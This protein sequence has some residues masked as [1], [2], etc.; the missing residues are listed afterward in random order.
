MVTGGSSDIVSKRQ[1]DALVST[2][3]SLSYLSRISLSMKKKSLS[4]DKKT[5]PR[6]QRWRRIM[7][8]MDGCDDVAVEGKGM[9]KREGV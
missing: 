8:M 6:S 9:R 5:K 3:F 1:N 2:P 4:Q 7:M